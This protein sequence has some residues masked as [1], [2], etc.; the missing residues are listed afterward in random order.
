MGAELNDVEC[1]LDYVKSCLGFRVNDETTM[2]ELV[3]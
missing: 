3:R 2:V 1:K